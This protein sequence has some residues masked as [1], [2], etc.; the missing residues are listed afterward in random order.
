MSGTVSAVAAIGTDGSTYDVT[1]SSL[2]GSGELRLDLKASGTG[3]VDAAR[4]LINSGFT[5]G[6]TYTISQTTVPPTLTSV[7]ISS[8]NSGSSSLARPG[9]VVTLK[10]TASE[11]ITPTVSIATHP[12]TATAGAGNSFTAVYTLSSSDAEGTVPFSIDFTNTAGTAGT[13]VTTTTNG[14]SVSFDK[15]APTVVS[16]NRQSPLSAST[17][18]TSVVFRVIFSEKVANVDAPDFTLTVLSGTVSGTVSAV[19]AIGTDGSTYDVTVSSLSGSG[20]LR[21]DLKASGTGIVDA[22]GNVINTGFTTGQTYTI[23]QTTVPPGFTSVTPLTPFTFASTTQ[24]K[25]QAKAWTYAGKW[26]CTLPVSDG[27]KIFRLDGTS[28]TAVLKILSVTSGRADCWVVGDLVHILAYKGASKASYI[29]SV[30]Y[31]P[32]GNTYKF[33]SKRPTSTTLVFPKGSETSTLAVDGTGRMWVTTA[34][35]SEVYAW[36]SDAPYSNWSDPITIATGIH[37]DDICAITALPGKIGIF[38][39]NQ[40]TGLFGFKTHSDG[41]NPSLWSADEKPAS[42]SA[43]SGLPRMAD[44]HMSL[45]VASD[46]TL[47]CAAKTSYNNVGYPQLIL[48]VRRPSG[49]WDNLYPVTVNEGTRIGTQPIILLNEALGKVKVVFTTET[50]GGDIVCKESFTS[51]ISFGP[52]QTLI[53]GGGPIYNFST[54]THQTYNPEVVIMATNQGV[55]P[56][57][58]VSVLA[59]DGALASAT[60]KAVNAALKQLP[61]ENEVVSVKVFPTQ[62]KRG[63]RVTVQTTSNEVTEVVVADSYGRLISV[64]RFAGTTSIDTRGMA[65]G[66]HFVILKGKHNVQTQKIIITD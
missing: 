56:F 20:D 65:T 32:A 66:M 61:T 37:D 30:Q 14:S 11:A 53:S 25:P 49:T 46:G 15:T 34:G 36:W 18:A 50:N 17:T 57:Q 10:F 22:V 28:W 9:D 52:I 26:W 39:S 48:L 31:D 58:V 12:V 42:Q 47:Y 55:K 63:M 44:D 54:S 35:V 51:S 6:Q 4:N 43:I 38:W 27:F 3:I 21:L 19:A 45:T 29:V 8:N 16:I 5:T 13:R 1:V 2:S 40:N 59:S 60:T 7:T 41:S 24:D 64:S 23:S 62:V 33:W